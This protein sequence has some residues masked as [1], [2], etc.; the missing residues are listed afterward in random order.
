MKCGEILIQV[1]IQLGYVTTMDQMK[2]LDPNNP[3]ALG[4]FRSE[5]E[6]CTLAQ[7]LAIDVFIT[8]HM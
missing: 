3:Q 1:W 6:L 4:K 8:Q 7:C 5:S 2:T